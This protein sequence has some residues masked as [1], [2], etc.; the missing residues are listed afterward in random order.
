MKLI[1]AYSMRNHAWILYILQIST[2]YITP[3]ITS[4]LNF[5]IW[6]KEN[7]R[8]SQIVGSTYISGETIIHELNKQNITL[9]HFTFDDYVSIVPLVT[10]YYQ[11]SNNN[12]SMIG[13]TILSK[14]PKPALIA[15]QTAQ[16]NTQ[17]R[18]IFKA[19]N[20]GWKH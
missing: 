11:N 5:T 7:D 14:F 1:P 3:R 19:S 18:R 16:N 9:L 20:I 13:P 15:Y 8:P 4:I 17:M 2:Q 12:P 6:I 10:E